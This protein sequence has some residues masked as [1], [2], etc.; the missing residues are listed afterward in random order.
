[1]SRNRKTPDTPMVTS[2]T[3]LVNPEL[4][5]DAL[6]MPAIVL[7]ADNK[8]IKINTFAEKITGLVNRDIQG[9]DWHKL[10]QSTVV[11]DGFDQFLVKVRKETGTPQ[12]IVIDFGI[13]PGSDLR[14]VEW[15]GQGIENG[16]IL[17]IGNPSA[18]NLPSPEIVAQE[19]KIQEYEKLFN[20]AIEALFIFNP[21]TLQ[22]LNVNEST[23]RLYG[24]SREEIIGSSMTKISPDEPLL[25]QS[26]H[27][28]M[29]LNVPCM[30]EAEHLTKSGETLWVSIQA[31]KTRYKDQPAVLAFVRDET[32]RRS[33][34][35]RL[36]NGEKRYRLIFENAP[37][38]ILHFDYEGT[39]LAC[40]P[41]LVEILGSSQDL[42]VGQNLILRLENQGVR[43]AVLKALAGKSAT[44]VGPYQSVT[45]KNLVQV[46][47]VFES[48]RSNS[49]EFLGGF[50][51]IQDTTAEKSFEA[52]RNLLVRAIAQ[53]SEAVIITDPAGDVIYVNPSFEKVTG[54]TRKEVIGENPRVL[55]SGIQSKEFYENLWSVLT[56]GE[57]WAGH[58]FNRRKNGKIYEE[59]AAITPV[60]DE[61]GVTTHYIAV[62]RDISNQV[63][64]EAQLKQAQK[65]ESVGRLAGGIAHDF[66]NLLTPIIGYAEML[67]L[68]AEKDPAFANG[69][70]R[71]L[72]AAERARSL[73][74]QLLAFGRKQLLEMKNNDLN[75]VL[76]KF[77]QQL[78]V[79]IPENIKIEWI[80]DPDIPLV[81]I[82]AQ[83]IEQV[84][85]N[86]A[87]NAQ[88]AME[89]G[90]TLT[91]SVQR[92][93]LDQSFVENRPEVKP[94]DY[95]L[96]SIK[97][98]GPG[99]DLITQSKIFE[100]FFTTKERGRGRGLGL[101]TAYGII[102][103]HG[104][105]IDVVS[106]TGHGTDFRIYLPVTEAAD[107]TG[108]INK[109]TVAATEKGTETILIVE[110]ERMALDLVV[111]FLKDL[112]YTILSAENAE[113]A[114][115]MSIDYP[116]EIHL[117]ITDVILPGIN[118]V[119]LQSQLLRQRPN[120][121]TLYISGYSGS[122]LSSYGVS[123][124]AA[125][126]IQK[127]FS[128]Q[129]LS[130]IIRSV[131]EQKH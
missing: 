55:K 76:E 94:G 113:S 83:Q 51:L 57:T 70:S 91:L 53:T 19:K 49:G 65:M 93:Q 127:P 50:G 54:Y 103:Q 16:D 43:D 101:A 32:A 108:L 84:L 34:E 45:G 62:K 66:N 92:T 18:P 30:I 14:F 114:I 100:P 77:I 42:I 15:T 20:D 82:D 37:F 5:F 36:I 89:N 75:E 111:N 129:D 56:S 3:H 79:S 40:N 61:N 60:L 46:S 97:D 52:E 87:S 81:R 98:T 88:D 117:L 116:G 128:I 22:I 109:E 73:T 105:Y 47:A 39:V 68:K 26:I 44:Y 23:C 124:K 71:I 99:M 13:T 12:R 8:I 6:P 107:K 96:L 28:V 78:K 33:A 64:I 38:G 58:F 130:G 121:R 29:I 35:E 126:F 41:R 80:P 10:F 118:G 63:E 125:N 85:M 48:V 24:Y 110:D 120:L 122:L 90:G 74:N 95:I 21:D 69:T 11:P 72:Q 115:R 119:E 67:H 31:S 59:E 9:Q 27:K 25:C 7:G 4:I 131:L 86:M 2:K 112:G 104:G 106:E 1:M 102:H 123:P 17:L